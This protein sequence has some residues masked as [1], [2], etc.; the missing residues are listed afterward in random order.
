ML[1]D[2]CHEQVFLSALV[3]YRLI[4]LV[5][6][7]GLCLISTFVMYLGPLVYIN[8]REAI[9]SG[10]EHVGGVVSSQAS[11]IRNITAE[12]TGQATESLK[13]YAGE[14]TTKAQELVGGRKSPVSTTTSSSPAFPVA[15][16]QEPVSTYQATPLEKEPLLAQ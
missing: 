15:P 4:K 10:I 11:Q 5:P 8:N 13:A 9:D 2:V 16:K 7:W 6:F 14:Y 3:S 12:R 1:A